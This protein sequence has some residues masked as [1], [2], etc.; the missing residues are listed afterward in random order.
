MIDIILTM[1]NMRRVLV[2][3]VVLLLACLSLSC[4]AVPSDRCKAWL[5]QSIPTDMPELPHVSGVLSTGSSMLFLRFFLLEFSFL[6]S[7]K[8]YG[9]EVSCN[10]HFCWL[11]S[12]K[13]WI[14]STFKIVFTKPLFPL[15]SILALFL[16][17]LR[18]C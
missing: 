16:L 17:I 12:E 10:N 8:S 9:L 2:Y 13:V 1:K 4:V 3:V 18:K 14:L 5:V 11:F 7:F 6:D 15:F